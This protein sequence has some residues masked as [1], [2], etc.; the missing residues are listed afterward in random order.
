MVSFPAPP[1]RGGLNF[2]LTLNARNFC[3]PSL[4]HL[5]G[6][7]PQ[8]CQ[9]ADSWRQ[10]SASDM[11]SL[12]H[13]PAPL[14]FTPSNTRSLCRTEILVLRIS[15]GMDSHKFSDGGRD[16]WCAGLIRAFGPTVEAGWIV[17][18]GVSPR[19][20]MDIA[21][22]HLGGGPCPVKAV[23]HP[24]RLVL[25]EAAFSSG[26]PRHANAFVFISL[27]RKRPPLLAPEVIDLMRPL[28]QPLP[29][30]LKHFHSRLLSSGHP[31]RRI[32]HD[33]SGVSYAP[34]GRT[35]QG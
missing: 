9:S 27:N 22:V 32:H 15:A 8:N 28:A 21:A 18:L 10:P 31:L 4:Y 12:F 24:P 16:P 7:L 14:Y 17:R 3:S 19:P 11:S 1:R 20:Q 5:Q 29:K 2:F 25:R 23:P 13:S 33:D 26:A 34:I 35:R 30:V 6:I